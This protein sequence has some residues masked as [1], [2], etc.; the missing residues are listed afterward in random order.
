M[1]FSGLLSGLSVGRGPEERSTSIFCYFFMYVLFLLGVVSGLFPRIGSLTELWTRNYRVFEWSFD[2]NQMGPV[3]DPKTKQK[4]QT[5]TLLSKLCQI[6]SK[7]V[8]WQVSSRGLRWIQ[9]SNLLAAACPGRTG[10][11]VVLL[12]L[13]GKKR[14][15]LYP[16][17]HTLPRT[18]GHQLIH[19][20]LTRLPMI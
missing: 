9:L 13:K 20:M 12:R 5:F 15:P 10:Q 17:T 7:S 2:P 4:V 18:P 14:M 6:I 3:L 8:R 16:N 19:N 11:L 1:V